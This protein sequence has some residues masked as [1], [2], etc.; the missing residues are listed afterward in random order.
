MK[1]LAGLFLAATLPIWAQSVVD[2]TSLDKLASKA[3]EVNKVS[4][5][6]DQ[7]QMALKMMPDN[8]KDKAEKMQ[9]V[10]QGLESVQVRNLEF[11]RAGEYVDKDLDVVREQ[12]AKLHGCTAIVDSKEKNEHSQVFM[13]SD[14]GKPSGIAVISAE[15]KEISVVLV[16][17]NL[18]FSQMGK[19][20]GLMGMPHMD[21]GP[22]P[23]LESK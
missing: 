14:N 13:C 15:A 1:Y 17:G 2:L 5:D 6:H 4:L 10:M 8:K 3:K 20:G 22:K 16:R 11:E 12:I 21:M 7:L 23:R 9:D 19:L 18:D